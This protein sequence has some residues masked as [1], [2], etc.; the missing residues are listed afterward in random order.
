MA[1]AARTAGGDMT[2]LVHSMLEGMAR[3][4]S[5]PKVYSSYL[6]FRM[7]QAALALGRDGDFPGVESV[8]DLQTIGDCRYAMAITDKNGQRYRV[9]VEVLP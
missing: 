8:G 6:A 9:T 1:T 3:V 5:M 7:K 4:A 2:T